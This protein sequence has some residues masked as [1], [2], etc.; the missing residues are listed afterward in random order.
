MNAG[1]T[2]K[3]EKDERIIVNFIKL[4]DNK[5]DI[6]IEHINIPIKEPVFDLSKHTDDLVRFMNYSAGDKEKVL[7]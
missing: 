5:I 2:L 4:S 1:G 6:N 7:I 3:S